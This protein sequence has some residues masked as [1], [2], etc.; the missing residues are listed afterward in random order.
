MSYTICSRFK[1]GGGI[2]CMQ[3]TQ[4]AP[5]ESI[6]CMEHFVALHCT[7]SDLMLSCTVPSGYTW[8]IWL[9]TVTSWKSADFSLSMYR[10]GI[11]ILLCVAMSSSSRVMFELM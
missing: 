1:G 3:G 9:G 5:R 6:L 11:Q 4:Y 10:S 8:I 7:Y 2:L